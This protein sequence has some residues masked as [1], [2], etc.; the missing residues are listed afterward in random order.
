[1]WQTVSYFCKNTG[2]NNIL[3][4]YHYF[5]SHHTHRVIMFFCIFS[6]RNNSLQKQVFK[7]HQIESYRV[8]T[9]KLRTFYEKV[10][11]FLKSD[12]SIPLEILTQNKH[13]HS[14]LVWI[15]FSWNTNVKHDK[16]KRN[17]ITRIKTSWNCFVFYSNC[18]TFAHDLINFKQIMD[19]YHAE[20]TNL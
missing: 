13:C 1:M 3:Q 7:Q 11:E 2:K 5:F 18:I 15:F 4:I 8:S 9:R 14:N 10:T 6:E 19:D 16:K 20:N 12:K 17:Y